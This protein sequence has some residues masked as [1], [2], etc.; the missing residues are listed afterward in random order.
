MSTAELAA[1]GIES[2]R[3]VPRGMS[4]ELL[5]TSVISIPVVCPVV[6]FLQKNLKG[7]GFKP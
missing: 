7:L 4:L 3:I 5:S 6:W 2:V 1:A